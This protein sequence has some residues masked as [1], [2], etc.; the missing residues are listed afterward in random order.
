MVT[1]EEAVKNLLRRHEQQQKMARQ[2]AQKAWKSLPKLVRI[3]SE[4]Y[5]A[6]RVILFG[7]LAREEFMINSDIDLA[8]SGMPTENYFKALGHLLMESPYACDLVTIEEAPD[9]LKQRIEEDGVILYD[10]ERDRIN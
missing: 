10:R 5:G 7:S 6:K 1:P 3:L 4:N 2:R 8:V 9:V